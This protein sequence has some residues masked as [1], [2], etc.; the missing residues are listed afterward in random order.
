[1]SETNTVDRGLDWYV[2]PMWYSLIYA[3]NGNSLNLSSLPQLVHLYL[4]NLQYPSPVCFPLN[5]IYPSPIISPEEPHYEFTMILSTWPV[6]TRL[7]HWLDP[8]STFPVR[9]YF[10]ILTTSFFRTLSYYT[11]LLTSEYYR[12]RM[13]P[14][15][16]Y[17][18]VF[19]DVYNPSDI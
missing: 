10:L 7:F 12:S 17:T 19:T 13:S 18:Q 3:N 16:P 9:P 15:S 1:M 14:P 5:K 8:Y 4:L 11:H 6:F 2:W